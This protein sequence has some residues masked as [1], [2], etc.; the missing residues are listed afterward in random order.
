MLSIFKT[1]DGKMVQTDTIEK[2]AWIDLIAPTTAEIILVSESLEIERDFLSAALDEEETSRIETEDGVTLVII[3]VPIVGNDEVNGEHAVIYS[4]LPLGVIIT[5]DNIVTVC[6]KEVPTLT[7][8]SSG[9]V[10]GVKTSY[11]TTFFFTLLL[12]VA[13]R[14]LQYLRQIDKI[15]NHIER[16]LYQSQRNKELIQLLDLEKSLV[17]FSTSL[18][19]NETTLEKI[20]RGRI[21]KLYDEDQ[22]LLEDVL[23]EVRQAIEMANIYSTI[24]SGTMDAFA[25]VISNNLN[26]TMKMLTSLTILITIPNIIYGFYGMNVEGLPLSTSWFP[27]ILSLG[28]MGVAG[29]ILK[30]FKLF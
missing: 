2:G 19:A 15:S 9:S 20:L 30:K 8:F 1:I 4:T 7:E 24:L 5:G 17:Y 16:K 14:F 12:R 27:L 18:K 28:V 13:N 11:K 3:D 10:R 26:V 23:I 29:L 6:L 21:I 25:S 22:D